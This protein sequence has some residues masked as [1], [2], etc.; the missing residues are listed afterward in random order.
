MLHAIQQK[1]FS[2][3]ALKVVA[4]IAVL[5]SHAMQSCSYAEERGQKTAPVN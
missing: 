3:F 2:S 4:K 5:I 1:N